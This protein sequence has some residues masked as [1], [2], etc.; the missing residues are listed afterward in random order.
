MSKSTSPDTPRPELERLR[1][2]KSSRLLNSRDFRKVREKG[3]SSQG[4]LL[5]LGVLKDS[6][7]KPTRIGLVTSK[8]VGGAVDRNKTRRRLRE[9][10]RAVLPTIAPGLDIVVVAKSS[11]ASASFDELR[12]EWLLLARRLSILPDSQ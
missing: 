5:R 4:R 7:P 6:D 1:F 3:K 10:I 8:R 9:M 11:A 12:A 2:P